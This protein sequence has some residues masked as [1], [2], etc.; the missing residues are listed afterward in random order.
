MYPQPVLAVHQMMA[1]GTI[2]MAMDIWTYY[3]LVS[4]LAVTYS[5][6]LLQGMYTMI[7]LIPFQV[8]RS[9]P[10]IMG[11]RSMLQLILVGLT[12]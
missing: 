4:R 6:E 8:L 12:L 5:Q 1:K 2:P 7:M 9:L 3:Q 10:E 11:T